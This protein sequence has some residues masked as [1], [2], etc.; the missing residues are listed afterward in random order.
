MRINF[1]TQNLGQCYER[2]PFENQKVFYR[3][4]EVTKIR[5]KKQYV[6]K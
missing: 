2:N 1:K 5:T 3:T 4:L 6:Y